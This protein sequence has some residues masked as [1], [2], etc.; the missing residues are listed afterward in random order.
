[1]WTRAWVGAAGLLLLLLQAAWVE[2]A[3]AEQQE[4]AEFEDEVVGEGR[5]KGGEA[6]KQPHLSLT[7]RVQRA[8]VVFYG[9]VTRVYKKRGKRT[10]PA[11]F[12]VVNVF[13]GADLMASLLQV[14]G[15][16]GGVYNLRD[17]RINVTNFGPRE[18]CLSP[19]KEQRTF[20]ILANA[21]GDRFLKARYDHPGG[22][23]VQ[24]SKENEEV[25]WRALGWDSWSDWSGCSASCDG[26]TQERRRYCLHTK[27]CQGYNVERRQCN[28]FTCNGT[29]DVLHL[30]DKQYKPTQFGWRESITRPGSWRAVRN[31]PLLVHTRDIYPGGFPEEF[32]LLITVRPDLGNMGMLFLMHRAYGGEVYLGLGLGTG[33]ELLHTGPARD[34]DVFPINVAP[35]NVNLTDGH[36]HQLAI[37]VLDDNSIQVYVDCRWI[38][39][40]ILRRSSL[41]IPMDTL[42][43]VG[44][45][46]GRSYQGEMEQFTVS[47]SPEAVAK[48]C[49]PEPIPIIDTSL[50]DSGRPL[51]VDRPHPHHT[52]DDYDYDDYAYSHYGDKVY[53]GGYDYGGDY[54][55]Y[56]GLNYNDF[57]DYVYDE[58]D[59]YTTSGEAETT[60]AAGATDRPS[61]YSSTTSS[62]APKEEQDR[63]EEKEEEEEEEVNKTVNEEMD[64]FRTEKMG[65]EKGDDADHDDRKEEEPEA[66]ERHS[67]ETEE[68]K[69]KEEEE[70]VKEEVHQDDLEEAIS[71]AEEDSTKMDLEGMEMNDGHRP[72]KAEGTDRG[73][74]PMA[75]DTWRATDDEDLLEGSGGGHHDKKFELAWSVWSGCSTSCDGGVRVR[76]YRCLPN[77]PLLEACV[78]AGIET[79]EQRACN[80]QPC[81]P[82]TT[83]PAP[84]I[85]ARLP[86]RPPG[87][88]QA[89]PY[90]TAT[91][92]FS[93][94]ATPTPLE[95]IMASHTTS[96]PSSSSSSSS[97]STTPPSHLPVFIPTTTQATT[98]TTTTTS[99]ERGVNIHPLYAA[100]SATFHQSHQR[101]STT[102]SSLLVPPSSSPPSSSSSSSIIHSPDKP[103]KSTPINGPLRP[104]EAP[105][106]ERRLNDVMPWGTASTFSSFKKTKYNYWYHH[107]HRNTNADNNHSQHHHQHHHQHQQQHHRMRHHHHKQSVSPRVEECPG[108]CLHQGLC[109]H[110]GV[111][112]CARGWGGR[113]CEEPICGHGGCRN[114]GVCVSPERCQCAPGYTG[115]RCQDAVCS[116]ECGGGGTCVLPGRCAC[117]PGLLPPTCT[118]MCT[119]RCQHGGECTGVGQCSC[120]A[121]YSGSRCESAVCSPP[122]QHR[123]ICVAPGVCSCP[124]GYGGARCERLLCSRG[125]G[126]GGKC[127][128]VERCQC[129]SGY[130]GPS[131]T[132]PLCDPPCANGGTC[133]RPG[134]CTCRDGYSGRWCSVRKC[135]YVPK[136]VEYTKT[137]KKAVPQQVQ[138]HCGAWGWKTCTSVRQSYQT[139]TQKYYRTVYTCQTPAKP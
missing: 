23:A 117:P 3:E 44:G 50:Q 38:S 74:M 16:Y 83:T 8:Q 93:R 20:I 52:A 2:S 17:K 71:S 127:V 126:V 19:L 37:S 88:I 85:A 130:S 24:W 39:R 34:D 14:D 78:R 56:N 66:P 49:K 62:P 30:Q 103:R 79:Q 132:V 109:G 68:E 134:V 11:E 9:F 111:C 97:S 108:G 110:G 80:L 29:L 64:V 116:P 75:V 77:Q 139:V 113:R 122:C 51:G 121:G 60:T 6:D 92:N 128:G 115:T 12:F 119:P 131:C 125:C 107:H 100:A 33:L 10:Y 98:T 90:M 27:G 18:D 22:A 118:P 35:I 58:F 67:T 114:G 28:F 91:N 135:K 25:V 1:M 138:T 54:D 5:C 120:P 70:T 84:L 43:Y 96:S 32:S 36:W 99:R 31:R 65:S 69:E 86:S 15:G 95:Q 42:L 21:P 40:Q 47:R 57:P 63:K 72:A 48:Q 129:G 13:K 82:T 104:Q 26:G 45:M 136:Q 53:V 102:S 137:Y 46:P 106:T 81:P 7:T 94:A 112:H 105:L 133:T 55:L 59:D 61:S 76:S 123:G 124:H 4:E 41:Q 89:I 101:T 73:K 87:L